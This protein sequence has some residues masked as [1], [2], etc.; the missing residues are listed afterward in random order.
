MT[1]KPITLQELLI[2]KGVT[3]AD[4]AKELSLSESHISLMVS[5]NRRMT[6]D[7][8]AVFSKRLGVTIDDIFMALDFA[9]R[10]VG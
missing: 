7:Y 3:Q 6:M 5:G 2:E 9:K 4:M 1:D 10:K 8:A